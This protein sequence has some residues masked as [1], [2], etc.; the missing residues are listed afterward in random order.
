MSTPHEPATSAFH[1]DNGQGR[2]MSLRRRDAEKRK[3]RRPFQPFF[4]TLEKRMMLTTFLVSTAADSG[5]A[6]CGKRS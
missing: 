1:D 2:K 5:P 4:H 6:R 3:K